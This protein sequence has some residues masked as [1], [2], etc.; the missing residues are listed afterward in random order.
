M[1]TCEVTKPLCSFETKG[2]CIREEGHCEPCISECQGCGRTIDHLGT[3]Y[4]ESYPIPR[5]QWRRGTCA[6]CTHASLEAEQVVKLNPLKASKRS[7]R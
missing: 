6:L 5:A 2:L 1:L 3:P 4:C 7:R